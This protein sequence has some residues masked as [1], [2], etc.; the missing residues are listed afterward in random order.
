[1][2]VIKIIKKIQANI[3]LCLKGEAEFWWG[4]ELL[5]ME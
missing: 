2:A 3:D 1:M 5:L 4:I